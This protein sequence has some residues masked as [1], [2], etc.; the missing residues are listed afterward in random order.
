MKKLILLA[1]WVLASSASAQ[2]DLPPLFENGRLTKD[3]SDTPRATPLPVAQKSIPTQ[4]EMP[5]QLKGNGTV[6]ITEVNVHGVAA[7]WWLRDGDT[8]RLRLYAVT[9]WYLF[10]HPELIVRLTA[11]VIAPGGDAA[12]AA[13]IGAAYEP[14]LNLRD[15]CDVWN[16]MVDRLNAVFPPP[17][18]ALKPWVTI[19]GAI[20]TSN[21]TNLT[22][23]TG[24]RVLAGVSCKP[25]VPAIITGVKVYYPLAVNT[26]G[27]ATDRVE[28]KQA[29][30]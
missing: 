22:G 28:C 27:A 17:L 26:G 12:Q 2:V 3:C 21:G 19:G 9:W 1:L 10:S 15:M 20:Y 23:L 14:T 18:P 30:P 25:D 5:K 16:P 13:A 8:V 7:G 6:A 4:A 11:L 29:T 24:R